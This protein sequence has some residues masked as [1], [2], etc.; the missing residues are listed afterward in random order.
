[1]NDERKIE[2]VGKTSATDRDPNTSDKFTFWLA[3]KVIVNPFDI[4]EVEQVSH[5]EKSKTF[6]L[7]TTLEHRTDS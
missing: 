7:V 2:E 5:E 4:V 3:P 1:M 6:G